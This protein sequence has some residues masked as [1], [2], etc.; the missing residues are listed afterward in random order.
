MEV[1]LM[2]KR[3]ITLL[4][5]LTLVL[6][7]AAPAHALEGEGDRA[8]AKLAALGLVN[9]SD[10]GY[11]CDDMATVEQAASFIVRFLG[12]SKAA[13]ANTASSGWK[14]VPVWARRDVNYCAA[15]GLLLG[16]EYTAG[17]ELSAE[18]W[19][20][21]LL[22]AVGFTAEEIPT[23]SAVSTALRTGLIAQSISGNLT[24][25][26]M[27][28]AALNA[29]RFTHRTEKTPMVERLVA[30]GL[31]S[32]ATVDALGFTER[33]LSAREIA[34]RSIASVMQLELYLDRTEYEKRDPDS[35]ATAF[36]I[37][38]DGLAVTN[39]HSIEGAPYGTA[40]LSNGER[41]DIE[42]VVY[43]S[44]ELDL[45]VI[46]IADTSEN[47]AKA[48]FF[49]ALEMASCFDVRL[50]DEVCTIGNPLGLG[51]AMSRGIV[52][53]TARTS[54]LSSMPCILFDATISKGSSG[55]PLFNEYGQ[56]IAVTTGAFING[57][58]LY[59]G[60]YLDPIMQADLSG[61]GISLH[62]HFLQEHDGKLHEWTA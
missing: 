48:T 37:S 31:C 45:A 26:M 60:V 7:F 35:H 9:G 29:L 22:R 30:R 55:G 58:N 46:R 21:M 2:A 27:F 16:E 28:E 51:L 1:F 42:R 13:R 5:S 3:I 62:D 25:G 10:K 14:N 43:S 15:K 12:E 49:P 40:L 39:H 38:E 32:R 41:Y 54:D 61:E 47:G 52:A 20:T 53:D 50:G 36:F 24:R 57:N 59:L 23:G 4:L 19:C 18:L 8:A 56:V 11:A 34:D 6:G 17:A 44:P 33:R